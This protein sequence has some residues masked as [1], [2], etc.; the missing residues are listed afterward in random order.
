M[1]KKRWKE[2]TN[3]W[4]EVDETTREETDRESSDRRNC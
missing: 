1:R 2:D 3:G 4:R